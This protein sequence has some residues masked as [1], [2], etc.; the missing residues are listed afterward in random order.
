MTEKSPA[1]VLANVLTAVA[2]LLL[3]YSALRTFIEL[4]FFAL[5]EVWVL[6]NSQHAAREE[7]E[8]VVRREIRGNFFTLDLKSAK[9]AFEKLAWVRAASL[10]RAWPNTLVVRLEEQVPLARW[11]GEALVN[12]HGERFAGVVDSPLPEFIGPPGAEGEMAK[13]YRMF[14]RVL[15]PIALAPISVRLSERGAWQLRLSND[16]SLELGREDIESRLAR[17][18][19]VY[20]QFMALTRDSPQRLDLRYDSGFAVT[21]GRPGDGKS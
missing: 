17:F 5:R 19:E 14:V 4:P 9:Q 10:S 15:Q 1:L 16:L 2:A 18:V 21:R 6:G 7:I 12:I 3:C 20:P 11:G 8:A 13:Q